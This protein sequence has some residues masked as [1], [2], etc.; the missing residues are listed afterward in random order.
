MS[1]DIPWH[2]VWKKVV[3]NLDSG[4]NR[5][6]TIESLKL[7][8][9]AQQD[10]GT[11]LAETLAG[12]VVGLA[13]QD[14]RRAGIEVLRNFVPQSVDVRSAV[15]ELANDHES[16]VRWAAASALASVRDEPDVTECLVK[17][18]DDHDNNVRSVAVSV[19]GRDQAD[20]EIARLILQLLDDE[21]ENVKQSVVQTLP[22]LG[23]AAGERR[24]SDAISL[25]V[26]P[27]SADR[28]LALGLIE[29]LDRAVRVV[30]DLGVDEAQHRVIDELILPTISELKQLLNF[31]AADPRQVR[32]QRKR[33]V[34]RIE[35]VMGA[36][37]ALA[38][39][40]PVVAEAG[41]AADNIQRAAE[42]MH[43]VAEQLMRLIAG[44]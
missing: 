9:A 28:A 37:R 41:P 4:Q 39:A 33:S 43:P 5:G 11:H 40:I 36:A 1:N 6:P 10:G 29:E 34:F 27:D 23:A 32:E 44:G 16:S 17:L 25:L 2:D 7:V 13:T 30:E 42:A 31:S 18:L 12:L 35:S 15:L 26:L 8:L 24:S 22:T 3:A 19:L 14:G 38:L 20:P 21:A